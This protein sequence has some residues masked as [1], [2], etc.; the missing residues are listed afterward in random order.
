MVEIDPHGDAVNNP[1]FFCETKRVE[2][3]YPAL[4]PIKSN[5]KPPFFSV[6][7]KIL[8]CIFTSRRPWVG[9]TRPPV[10]LVPFSRPLHPLTASPPPPARSPAF[11]AVLSASPPYSRTKFPGKVPRGARTGRTRQN[12]AGARFP[13]IRNLFW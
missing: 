6:P 1:F 7:A 13:G 9:S 8:H 10:H 2:S 12:V 3:R 5:P 11:L 4:I